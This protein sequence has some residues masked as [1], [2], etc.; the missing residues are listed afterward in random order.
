M[1]MMR[2]ISQLKQYI[3]RKKEQ[4]LTIGFVPTMGY[5]HEGHMSLMEKA[6]SQ[7][8]IVVLSI[9]VNPLQFGPNEDFDEY[10]RD[11]ERDMQIARNM[12][13]DVVFSPTTEEIYPNKIYT[14]V[15]V[16]NLTSRLCGASRPGHFD[17]V[18]TV[19]MKLLNIVEPHKAYFGQKDA[20]QVAVIKQMVT[21]LNMN[22][23]IVPCPIIREKDGLALSSRNVYLDKAEREQAIKLFESLEQSERWIEEQNVTSFELEQ[24][25]YEHISSAHLANIDYIEVLSFPDMQP[26]ENNIP[27]SQLLSNHQVIIALA[28]KFGTTRLID[29][30]IYTGSLNTEKREPELGGMIYV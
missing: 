11:M 12:N 5:L 27:I 28:V 26:I 6:T 24:L 10:P 25:L 21:D 15:S 4:K 7:C 8:D 17:G 2:S 13:V 3:H 14:T 22:V 16:S 20:Q 30:R 29:N 23:E 18:S 9:Y 19:V 1:E